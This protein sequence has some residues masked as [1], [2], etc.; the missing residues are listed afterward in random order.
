M[1]ANS[2]SSPAQ[3]P[4]CS[5]IVNFISLQPLAKCTGLVLIYR[6]YS[7]KETVSSAL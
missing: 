7:Y 3:V 5:V 6:K 2:W 1:H 4:A